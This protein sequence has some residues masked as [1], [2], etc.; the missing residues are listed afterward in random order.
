MQTNY[1]T[2]ASGRLDSRGKQRGFSILEILVALIVASIALTVLVQGLSQ[3]ANVA[4]YLRDRLYAQTIAVSELS[5]KALDPEYVMPEFVEIGGKRL[6]MI[7]QEDEFFFR[8]QQGLSEATLTVFDDNER[9]I[10]RVSTIIN[11]GDLP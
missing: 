4:S 8:N 3:Y 1:S 2:M 5:R 7:L 11:R 10:L 9:E 6:E